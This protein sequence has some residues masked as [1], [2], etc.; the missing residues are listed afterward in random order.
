MPSVSNL[1]RVAA[2]THSRSAPDNR[3]RA[4][5]HFQFLRHARGEHPRR[6][7]PGLQD[8]TLAVAKQPV[9]EQHLG[10]LGGFARA[11]GSLQDQAFRRPEGSDEIGFNFVNG[12]PFGHGGS[13]IR[14][15][16]GKG[17]TKTTSQTGKF[18]ARHG[19][20]SAVGE[21]A[22]SLIVCCLPETLRLNN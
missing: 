6:E 5:G 2:L 16:R 19:I 10:D 12:Q 11:G 15:G 14:E 18:S 20:G 21:V 22:M 9:L 8:N 7:P 13:L 1:I 4:R 17:E 3:L